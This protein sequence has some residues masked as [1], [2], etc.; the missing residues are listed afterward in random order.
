MIQSGGF[1]H[2]PNGLHVVLFQCT[3]TFI[4]LL[5]FIRIIFFIMI[6][7]VFISI[8]I[9]IIIIETTFCPSLPP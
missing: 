7:V 2:K 3:K 1:F 4:L 5:F 6:I 8:I 9:I